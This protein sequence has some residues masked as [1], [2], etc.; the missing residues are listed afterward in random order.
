MFEL[1]RLPA[2]DEYGFFIHPDLLDLINDDEEAI[3]FSKLAKYEVHTVSFDFDA[4]EALTDR[5]YDEGDMTAVA[6]WAP[7]VPDATG[8]WALIAKVDAEDSPFAIFVKP[9]EA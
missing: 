8:T 3:D 1:S 4:P 2:P 6:K 7:T 5:F 9:A